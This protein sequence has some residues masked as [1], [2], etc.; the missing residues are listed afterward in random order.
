[1]I[2]AGLM[3][4][5][6]P[7][8]Y[9]KFFDAISS[10]G[11]REVVASSLV[12]ILLV[13]ALLEFV[14]WIFW[15]V[16]N[17]AAN[18]FETGVIADLSNKCFAY[19]HK[20]SYSYFIDNFGGSLVKRVKWFTGAFEQVT[21]KVVWNILPLVVGVVSMFIVLSYMSPLLGLGV[22]VWMIFFLLASVLFIRYKLKYDI[23]GS[24]AETFATGLLADTVS[25]HNN[26]KLFNGYLGEIKRYGEAVA[27]LRKLRFFSWNLGAAFD[28]I[29]AFL[30][31]ALELGAFFFAVSLWKSGAITIGGFVLIQTYLMT[32]IGRMWDFGRTV[33]KIYQNLADAEEMTV[34]LN[35][36]HEIT[37]ALD[38]KELSVKEG[39][40]EFVN[41]SFD[42][43]KTRT[44]FKEFNLKINPRESLAF[45]GPSGAGKTTIVKLLFRMHDLS[46]GKI[47]IDE[48][49]I[50]KVTQE[51]LWRNISLVPQD[52]ILFHRTLMENIR[53]GKPEASDEEVFAAAKAAHCHEFISALSSGYDTYVGERGVKLSGGERQRVAI[54]RAILRNAPILVLDEATSSLDSESEYLIQDALATLMKNKTVIVIAH[55]L[56]TVRKVDRIVV[57]EDGA[58]VE[59]GKH[60]MLVSR[61]GG[62]YSK[63]W[64]LQ[65]GGFEKK[66][67]DSDEVI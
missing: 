45:I 37:D 32:I 2:G 12:R 40:I 7:L 36:P 65:A 64:K 15:R 23:R 49:D 51:S 25:N 56:S 33:M 61:E 66:L 34:I 5:I 38:A 50:S 63:L 17:I 18:Y 22:L 55:R 39:R 59:E 43:S 24:E 46:G 26:V 27:N 19:L 20:H 54:A 14:N 57:V 52:P 60:E 31:I 13:V 62:L 16:S 11:A 29:Q 28:S 21:D 58:I 42:Y 9:K 47:L 8:F 4:V 3:N 6:I 44:I 10:G 30:M 67:A 1:M 41:A 48:Q 53:Y 35:T